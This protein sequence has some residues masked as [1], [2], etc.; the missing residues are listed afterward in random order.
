VDEAKIRVNDES[1][2]GY[3]FLVGADGYASIVRRFIRV[4][5]ERRLIG[6]QYRVPC[7]SEEPRFEVFLHPK[8]FHSWYGWVFSHKDHFVTGTVCDPAIIPSSKH[9]EKFRRWL[10]EKNINLTDA[11]YE[12]YPI[13]Y[14]YREI[15]YGNVFLVGDAG[16][17]ASGLTGEGIYQSLIS[18]EA[19]ARMILDP[20]HD[21]ESLQQVIRYN[22]IQH[23][24]MKWFVG[25][26]PFRVILQ[27][28]ILLLMNLKPL[29]SK[30]N[31]FF[32]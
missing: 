9:A 29:K 31:S 20:D 27:E 26:G 15:R 4:P 21:P 22:R 1:E 32:N 7:H 23:R 28:L 12:S 8:Y 19:A 5:V 16:G 6:M 13:C 25:A 10:R 17:F 3:R 11:V 14:D 2:Y 30:I 18:G 24:A